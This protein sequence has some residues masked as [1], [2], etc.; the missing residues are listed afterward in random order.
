[1]RADE[2]RE[3]KICDRREGKGWLQLFAWLVQLPVA[4]Q[5]IIYQ[6]WAVQQERLPSEV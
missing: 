3:M 5:T 4:Y 2:F 6:G 1:M